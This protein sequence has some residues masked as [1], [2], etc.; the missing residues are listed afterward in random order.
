MT[1]DLWHP[2]D[3]DWMTQ[4]KQEWRHVQKSLGI[5]GAHV[6]KKHYKYHKEL[7]FFGKIE[8]DDPDLRYDGGGPPFANGQCFFE[9]WY[10]PVVSLEAYQKIF[11]RQT[12]TNNLLKS[13][14][15]LFLFQGFEFPQDYGMLGGREE[16]FVKVLIPSYDPQAVRQ[17]KGWED[18]P[19]PLCFSPDELAQLCIGGTSVFLHKDAQNYNPNP[20]KPGQYLWD[21][22]AHNLPHMTNEDYV[23][24]IGTMVY[25]IKNHEHL[26]DFPHDYP[27][28]VNLAKR[29]KARL[30][31]RDFAEPLLKLY[32]KTETL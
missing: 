23:R 17:L 27:V 28:A 6:R 19:Y 13:R 5:I 22:V 30:D 15:L 25:R 32:D 21:H 20:Y 18:K 29:L 16:L 2:E 24:W 11:D 14:R 8:S 3:K 9:L 1:E 31:A 4:R 12:S 7:F 26:N 10:H